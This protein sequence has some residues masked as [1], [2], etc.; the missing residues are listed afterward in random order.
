MQI[1]VGLENN[2]ES[3]SLAWVLDHPGCFAYGKD[4]TEA[5]LRVPQALIT[6]REWIGEKTNASWLS[7][8]EDFDIALVEVFECYNNLLGDRQIEINACFQDDAR[9]FSAVEIEQASLLLTWSR[10]DL[11]QLISPLTRQQREQKFPGE[12]WSIDG[13][14]R[15]VANA[16][17]WYLDRLE[18][19]AVSRDQLS[20]NPVERLNQVHA[21][22]MN[23]LP[24]LKNRSEIL[25]VE[26][27]T[28]SARK[29][30]RRALWHIRD[31][32]FHIERLMS[33]L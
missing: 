28:W 7:D 25:E 6:Y 17:W 13:V 24:A 1:R 19:A 21:L 16:N 15:H 8:L 29:V 30:L 22:M 20:N 2:I 18:L 32:H 4:G 9:P 26:G 12:R 10:D 31:H 5:I 11:E 3:R 23:S 14:V 27:E 33:L